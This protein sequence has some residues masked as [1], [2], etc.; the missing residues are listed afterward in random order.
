MLTVS[1]NDNNPVLIN[2]IERDKIRKNLGLC[3]EPECNSTKRERFATFPIINATG[4]KLNNHSWVFHHSL[5]KLAVVER[6]F[7]HLGGMLWYP[8]ASTG[9]IYVFWQK[10]PYR[11]PYCRTNTKK[12]S[13]FFQGPKILIHLTTRSST[14][15]PFPLLRKKLKIK[16]L[17]KYENSS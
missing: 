10:I 5:K 17:S 8:F 9:P 6:L 16:L 14:L 15:N 7:W 2:N 11:L 1:H 3:F 13:P 4:I 12:F